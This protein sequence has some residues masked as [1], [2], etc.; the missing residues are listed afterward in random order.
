M[1]RNLE[2]IE[3]TFLVEKD[4]IADIE[5]ALAKYRFF[6][7]P[8]QVGHD[9][10][11]AG[12]RVLSVWTTNGKKTL[13]VYHF[14]RIISLDDFSVRMPSL[15]EDAR[16]AIR[17]WAVVRDC[18]GDEQAV[19]A[20]PRDKW[21]LQQKPVGRLEEDEIQELKALL[22]KIGRNKEAKKD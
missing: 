9:V 12:K 18:F 7:L 5:A 21:V 6:E 13:T 14:G 10:P 1:K 2:D 20:R 17:L 15:N 19:D 16:R 4:K 11:D 22:E 8:A 3:R